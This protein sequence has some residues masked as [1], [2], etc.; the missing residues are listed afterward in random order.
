MLGGKPTRADQVGP[1]CR[2]EG[3]GGRGMGSLRPSWPSQPTYR[4]A[5]SRQPA[6]RFATA[7]LGG[8][9]RSVID[10]APHVDVYRSG[11][12]RSQRRLMSD[13]ASH[14][15]NWSAVHP[16]RRM[17]KSKDSGLA[18]TEYV[19]AASALLKPGSERPVDQ[20]QLDVGLL[21]AE[22]VRDPWRATRRRCGRWRR[23]TR[24]CDVS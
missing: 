5:R 7:I 8:P 9:V 2:S 14:V 1:H 19:L 18:S 20:Q 3:L 21:D 13:S 12:W 10:C 22:S 6:G 16:C 23:S 11:S 4:P 17:R 24:E 15:S